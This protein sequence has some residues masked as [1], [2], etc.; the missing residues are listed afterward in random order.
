M[1]LTTKFVQ[2]QENYWQVSGG[3][4]QR[5]NFLQYNSFF[6]VIDPTALNNLGYTK[7]SVL[8][9][10]DLASF[11][12]SYS[13]PNLTVPNAANFLTTNWNTLGWTTTS[14]ALFMND[15]A[16]FMNLN[17]PA[18]AISSFNI[19]V[20]Y[21][22]V[23]GSSYILPFFY[24]GNRTTGTPSFIQATGGT[25][26]TNGNFRVHTFNGSGTFTIT[27][28][29]GK[30]SSLVVGGGGGGAWGGGGGGQVIYTTPGNVYGP[31]SY[32]ITVG[33]GGSGQTQANGGNGGSST[34][35]VITAVGGGG[36]GYIISPAFSTGTA[37][38]SGASGGGGG[39]PSGGAGG[40]AT[41]GFAG[42]QGGTSGSFDASGGGGGAGGVGG[43]PGNNAFG[44]DGGLGVTNSITGS[45]VS[46]GGGGGGSCGGGGTGG[47][48]HGGGGNGTT[49]GGA[50]GTPGT[51]NT[52]GGGGGGYSVNGFAGGSGVVILSYQFQ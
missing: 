27:G 34:F 29:S 1:S 20:V 35:D 38:S 12:S 16:H 46:Y 5:L 47:V 19:M 32:S 51:A 43:S 40:T 50:A 6:Y 22:T 24:E 21:G 13:A 4:I 7:T 45:A 36:G 25:I 23:S 48:G 18:P 3:N 10:N 9:A 39:G 52:G 14:V 30:I 15:F 49:N 37:G 33:A 11:H 17:F 44:G 2:L 28:G 31:G 41:A 42:G 8:A 26:T